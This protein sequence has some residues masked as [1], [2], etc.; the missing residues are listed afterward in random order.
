MA[1]L[2]RGMIVIAT[3]SEFLTHGYE[4]R[5]HCNACSRDAAV[6]LAALPPDSV[7]AGPERRAL[8]CSVCSSIDVERSVVA[9]SG[10]R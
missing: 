7:L 1:R 9:P 3:A 5:A 6:P 8:R 2:S 10:P 4:L